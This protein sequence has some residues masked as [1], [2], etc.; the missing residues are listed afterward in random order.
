MFC[1]TSKL[2]IACAH[3]LTNFRLG[4]IKTAS[5][6]TSNRH[7]IKFQ[8]TKNPRN[9]SRPVNMPLLSDD[10][11]ATSAISTFNPTSN[12]DPSP[13]QVAAITTI[14]TELSSAPFIEDL[15]IL[16]DAYSTLYFC[17]LLQRTTTLAWSTRMTSC[18]GT[19]SLVLDKATKRPKHP[20]ECVVR[21]SEPL[22]KFRP[23]SDTIN[24]L[25]HEMIHAYFFV[26]GGKHVRGD[27]PT[28]HGSGF[29]RMAFAIN[30]HGGYEITSTHTFHAE[31]ENYQTHVWQCTG[32]CRDLAPYFGVVK[33]AMNRPPGP[34]DSWY[35]DHQKKCVGGA[36]I[37]ISEPPPKEK[38][39]GKAT[40]KNKIDRWIEKGKEDGGP[41]NNEKS[42]PSKNDQVAKKRT[43]PVDSLTDSTDTN[44]KRQRA[45]DQDKP[46]MEISQPYMVDCPVCPARLLEREI[47]AHLD[48][49]HGF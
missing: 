38:K 7:H 3:A 21:L 33:R 39:K 27:D 23:R 22:L 15:T 43:L 47:N 30:E 20:R 42:Q 37:K 1:S 16:F 46:D 8:P 11:A 36:W 19:C 5:S 18:A 40:Q 25:L 6:S 4:S 28:G 49:A 32:S 35:L 34:S 31:V 45:L 44:A 26:A 41:K 9:S 10:E 24:T 12:I 13:A 17:S 29:Q 2:G 48:G 14:A